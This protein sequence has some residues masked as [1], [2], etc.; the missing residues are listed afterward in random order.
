MKTEEI[1]MVVQKKDPKPNAKEYK[2]STVEEMFSFLNLKNVERFLEDFST[3]VK[4]A[5]LMKELSNSI[6]SGSVTKLKELTWIDD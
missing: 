2:F 1:C 6:E 3:G 4:A 5:V